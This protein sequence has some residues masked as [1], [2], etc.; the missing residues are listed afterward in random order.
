[1]GQ[2]P[3][4]RVPSTTRQGM[5]SSIEP[6]MSLVQTHLLPFADIEGDALSHAKLLRS[7][8]AKGLEPPGIGSQIQLF[9]HWHLQA[10]FTVANHTSP[11]GVGAH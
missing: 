3:E 10:R 7:L 4:G 8:T 1:M 2:S 9:I 5:S 6:G 11:A